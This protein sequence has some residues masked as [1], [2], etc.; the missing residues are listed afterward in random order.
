V[1]NDLE[2]VRDWAEARIK[3]GN[4]PDWSWDRHVKLIEAVDAVLHDMSVANEASRSAQQAG[5]ILR[6][7]ECARDHRVARFSGS[8]VP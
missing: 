2:K 6:L 5:R 1:K 3:A 4:V 7:V 8:P